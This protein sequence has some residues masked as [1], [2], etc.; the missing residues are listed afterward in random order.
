MSIDSSNTGKY[1]ITGSAVALHVEMSM[2]KSIGNEKFARRCKIVTIE[3]LI[4]ELCTRN[5]IREVTIH[6]TC[7]SIGLTLRCPGRFHLRI[8]NREIYNGVCL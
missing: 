6:A 7:V 2:Q 1:I 5:Y 4:M 8:W 3:S